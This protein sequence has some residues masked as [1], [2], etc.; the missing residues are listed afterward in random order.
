MKQKEIIN[1]LKETLKKETKTLQ[2]KIE[3]AKNYYSEIKH[4]YDTLK[5]QNI[6]AAMN[7]TIV[8]FE[9][10]F[11]QLKL[12]E[13]H[14]NKQ[15]KEQLENKIKD[16]TKN[17]DRYY[18]FFEA[19]YFVKDKE[20]LAKFATEYD[21]EKL[22]KLQVEFFE[23]VHKYVDNE[24]IDEQIDTF[25]N[26]LEFFKDMT[27]D[28]NPFFREILKDSLEFYFGMTLNSKKDLKLLKEII[29]EDIVE[30]LKEKGEEAT[31]ETAKE[32]LKRLQQ[33]RTSLLTKALTQ[34]TEFEM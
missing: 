5:T 10:I 3:L 12:A 25:E 30:K 26:A 18:D 22:E 2:Q 13:S 34:E 23:T 9:Y 20:I 7:S 19:F 6:I 33:E 32:E 17:F 14:E 21:L 15:L 27:K 8:T 31:F 28:I 1:K 11:A 16:L 24:Y 29:K 4:K